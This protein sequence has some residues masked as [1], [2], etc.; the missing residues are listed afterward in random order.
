MVL[1]LKIFQKGLI[2]KLYMICFCFVLVA[3]AMEDVSNKNFSTK[4]SVYA[5][6][7]PVIRYSRSQILNILNSSESCLEYVWPS[8]DNAE[9]Q[10]CKTISEECDDDDSI[11]NT[12]ITVYSTTSFFSLD[13]PSNR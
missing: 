9:T 12:E 7:K 10:T 11:P 8:S 13:N 1:F 5:L 2:M 3:Y 4:V 6:C